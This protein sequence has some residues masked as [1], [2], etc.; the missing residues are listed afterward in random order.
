MFFAA[1]IGIIIGGH[2]TLA[3][4]F[5]EPAVLAAM[6]QTPFGVDC[7]QSQVAGSAEVPIRRR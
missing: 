6:R 7:P 2:R 5:I 4:S 1:T 3:V